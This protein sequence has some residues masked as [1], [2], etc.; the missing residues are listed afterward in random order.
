M[1][2]QGA[3]KRHCHNGMRGPHRT[4]GGAG[5]GRT[6]PIVDEG[7]F[8]SIAASSPIEMCVVQGGKIVLANPK[9]LRDAG[10]AEGELVG[11]GV[12]DLVL[13]ADRRSVKRAAVAMLRGASQAPYDFR[14]VLRTGDVRWLTGT[15]APIQFEGRPA[16]LAFCMDVTT[17]RDNELALARQ[18]QQSRVIAEIGRVIGSSLDI[19]QVYDR[20]AEEVRR[21]ITFDQIVI[22]VTSPGPDSLTNAYVA[23]TAD[24]ARPQ[25]TTMPLAGSITQEVVRTRSPRLVLP[26]D[27][28]GVSDMAA[29]FPI[30]VDPMRTGLRSIL[31]APLIS[32]DEVIG[33]LILLSTT[34]VAY[35][36]DDLTLIASIGAQIAGAIA[37]SQ[38]YL[39]RES[40][41][42]EIAVI[43]EIAHIITSNLDIGEVY[44]QFAAAVKSLVNFD[45]L[46]VNVVDDVAQTMSTAKVSPRSSVFEEGVTIPLQGTHTGRVVETARTVLVGDM[47]EDTTFTTSRRFAEAGLR[48]LCSMPLISKDRV[49][50]T[51]SL[52]SRLLDAYSARDVDILERLAAQIA[53]AVENSRLYEEARLRAR[54]MEVIAEVTRIITSTLDVGEVYEGF[55]EAVGT[56]VQFDRAGI[57][58]IDVAKGTARIAYLSR[59]SGSALNQGE[60]LALDG[61]VTGLA[62]SQQRTQVIADMGRTRFWTAPFLLQDGLRSVIAVPLISKGNVIGTFN[63]H[64]KAPVLFEPHEQAVLERLAAQIAPAIE[65]S[66]LFEETQRLALALES[67]GDGVLFLDSHGNIR[68]MNA[69]TEEVFGY[70]PDEVLNK[71]LTTLFS[72]HDDQEGHRFGFL[73]AYLGNRWRDEVKGRRKDGTELDVNLTIT[74]VKER[75]GGVIGVVC[76]AQD[77]TDRKAQRQHLQEAARLASIRELAAGVAHEINNPLTV[78]AGFAEVLLDKDLPPDLGDYVQ[79]IYLE[80]QRAAKV[81]SNLLS[82]ARKH[83]PERRYV[84]VTNAVTRAVALKVYDFTVSNISIAFDFPRDVPYTMADEHQLQQVFLNVIINAEQAMKQAHGRGQLRIGAAVVDKRIR[85]SIADDGPGIA[86]ENLPKIFDPFFTTKDVG[87][88]T[89]LGLSICYGTVRQHGGEIWAESPTGE[90]TTIFVELPIVAGENEPEAESHG[91]PPEPAAPQ[92]ILVVD[93]ESGIRDLLCDVLSADGHTVDVASD[94]RRALEMI[95]ANEY[96]CV[97]LDLKMPGVSGQELYAE[98]READPGLASKVIFSTGDTARAEARDFLESTGNPVLAKPFHLSDLRQHIRELTVEEPA[99]PAP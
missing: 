45:R 30:F 52:S 24:I 57:N 72:D 28:E 43:G 64:R 18:A 42:K 1:R 39:E 85:I 73:E 32:G 34:Y 55:A 21:L 95:G 59:Q 97:I 19:D 33:A 66:Q 76:T 13:Q 94:G 25:G 61:T 17:P 22:A 35:D 80:S 89:G 46:A 96:G 37:N 65:N 60:T 16:A 2:N 20:F 58:V 79:R 53:P 69:A 92:R 93:D 44:D 99:K 67:I 74:P 49:I 48:T 26:E 47:A 8:S 88:G 90:G 75:A 63:L 6:I 78:V 68:F 54:E 87:D 98:L 40:A 14:V 51:L 36:E 41:H 3:T 29:R 4:P 50:A 83:E 81:V 12:L 9:L 70:R 82:F 38:L 91:P 5:D 15:V 86:P 56:L 84:D 11:S 10:F 62:V 7:F 27:E 31:A 77:I 23:G 71:P